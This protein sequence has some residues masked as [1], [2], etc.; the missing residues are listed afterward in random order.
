MTPSRP[1]LL[2]A[3]YNWI[4]DNGMTLEVTRCATDGTPNAC[5]FLYAAAWRATKA[6]GFRKLITYILITE[7]GTSL[8]AAGWKCLGEAGGGSWS[9]PSRPTIDKHPLQLK[10]KWEAV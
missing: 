9:S 1:Y 7:P 6:L 5:S 10:L 3:L 2:R 4:L 8:V